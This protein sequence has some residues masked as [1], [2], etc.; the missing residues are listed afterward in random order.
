MPGRQSRS[1][2]ITFRVS[3]E[4]HTALM[5]LSSAHRCSLSAFVRSSMHSLVTDSELF[6]ELLRPGGAAT[7]QRGG[8]E[9]FAELGQQP[10]LNLLVELQQHARALES[11]VRRLV[12]VLTGRLAATQ[13][14]DSLGRP[15]SD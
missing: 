10:V 1:R 8:G 11:Q 13:A 7:A 2:L 12:L 14:G 15:H 6:L 9:Q 4:E 3:V 5:M